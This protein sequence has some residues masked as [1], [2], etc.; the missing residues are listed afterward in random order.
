MINVYSS[1][2]ST[3][4]TESH[5]VTHGTIGAWLE[6]NAPS[7]DRNVTQQFSVTIDGELVHQCQ[8][9]DK[10]IDSESDIRIVVE[11]KGTELFF[12]AL[13]LAATRMMTPKIPKMN[14]LAAAGQGKDLDSATAKGNKVKINQVRPEVAGKCR[15]YGN[16]A[17]P[18]RRFFN[19]KRD[20]RVDLCL[21]LGVGDIEVLP[22]EIYIGLTPV[23]SYGAD[24][25]YAIY[26]PG[27]S[28]AADR[29]ADWW[30]DVQEVGSGS[31]G[32]SGLDMTESTE[33]TKSY[34]AYS[35]QMN[36]YQV[37]IPSGA[38]NF[39]ADWTAG[40]IVRIVVP[41]QY[42]VIDD[43]T[44]D[45]IEGD[46]LTMLAPVVGQSIEIVGASGGFY[47]VRS[48]SP[49]VPAVPAD[50]GSPAYSTGSAAPSTFNF[51]TTPANF[52]V[53]V[54]T[55]DYPVTI[56]TNTTNMAGLISAINAA[57]P[58]GAPFVASDVGGR[59]RCTDN[60]SVNTGRALTITGDSR[61]FGLSTTAVAGV[62]ATGG[63][64][65]VPPR[66][67][68]N[69][70]GQPAKSLALGQ[71]SMCI[72]PAGLRY[73]LTAAS[74]TALTVVRLNSTGGND[75]SFPGFTYQET[76]GTV[77]TL[78]Q[79][80]LQGGFRGP[81]ACCPEGEKITK[82]QWDVFHPSGLFGLGRE[83]QIYDIRSFHRL[84]W[85]D[86]DLAGAWTQVDIEHVGGKQDAM[87]FTYELTLP[88]PMRAEAR[89]VKRF[90]SQ[91]GRIDNEKQ[92]EIV[93]YGLRGL[94]PRGRKVYPNSTI[95]CLTVRGGDRLSAE[96]EA[97]V[98]VKG[99]RRLPVRRGGVWQPPEPTRD[100][101]PFALHVLK[102]A[103]YTDDAL[104]L[105][106][107]DALDALYRS[108]GDRY[109]RLHTE[110]STV[111]SVLE[112]CLNAGFARLT[113]KHGLLTPVRDESRSIFT[114][115]YTFDTQLEGEGLDIR[116]NM[117]SGDDYDGV[118]VQYTDQVK[119][120]NDTVKCRL[121]GV[122]NPKKVKVIKAEGIT[123][124]LQAYRYGMRDLMEIRYRR[125]TG[126]WA[127]EM[128]AFNSNFGDL[129]QVGG[130]CPGYAQS[131]V[132]RSVS[133][134][135]KTFTLRAPLD[136]SQLA[137]PYMASFRRIDG[138]CFG[139]A[140]V[141]NIVGDRTFTIA[142]PL[143]FDPILD[144]PGTVLPTYVLFGNG[145]GVLIDEIDPEGT[146]SAR[147]KAT[148]YDERVY[149]YDDAPLPA[150]A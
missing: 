52:T 34:V 90:V 11:P 77:I 140:L 99:T 5:A 48:F 72:G 9:H 35:H 20:Q 56:N 14:S 130:E 62:A 73:R 139:P 111:Q 41:Y 61:I 83:G 42:N 123:E 148:F 31:N 97:Q 6:A 27:E 122:P 70:N 66:M 19:D 103:G 116:F 81:F 55:T 10:L 22:S 106:E 96:S 57:K 143:D 58:S 145:Y 98:W 51:T 1:K 75:N 144:Q 82:I 110:E 29:R 28:L 93:W 124:R 60:A 85:R 100:I 87:G 24:V 146:E 131:H 33:L 112:D 147:I 44:A 149:T 47:T 54:G 135:K 108:R 78:D 30:H 134:D 121:P 39:P 88:Y 23:T 128:A 71:Q 127:S 109:D 18:A 37:L 136:L 46:N 50:P 13:F 114:A 95:L 49:K 119:W 8:W 32:S 68:L 125:K 26:R 91:P 65:E 94:I 137:P 76:T 89:I 92:D 15:I 36:G 105:E 86:M 53:R 40:L 102:S 45:I 101:V 132:M 63:T 25:S 16:Y 67:T 141:T 12:G 129:V 3:E 117:I 17:K 2:F 84:E 104:D 118:D 79:S 74:T 4:P 113:V 64:P 59:V 7:Y 133:A 43:A 142:N 21:D 126:E 115:L 69:L 150:G 38:G 107:W 138:T 120:Q 80:N